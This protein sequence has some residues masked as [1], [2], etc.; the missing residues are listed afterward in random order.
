MLSIAVYSS[1]QEEGMIRTRQEYE[2]AKRQLERDR[3]FAEQQ[4]VALQAKGLT[5][6]AVELAMQ[7]LLTFCAQHEEEV[8]WYER[9]LNRDFG[10]LHRLSDIGRWLIGLRIASGLSQR[11]LAQRLDVSESQVSRDERN[12][13]YGVSVTRAQAILDILLEALNAE[14]RAEIRSETE[15]ELTPV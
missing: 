13:Y 10:Q 12:E 7:P 5:P 11:D 14:M 1:R 15:K 9:V 3:Q 4:R 2:E 8:R 6:D